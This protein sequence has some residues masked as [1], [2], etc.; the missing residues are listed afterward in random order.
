MNGI[1]RFALGLANMPAATVADLEKAMPGMQRLCEIATEIAAIA[2][3]NQPLTAHV[4][5][6][7][8]IVKK[9]YP[10]FVAVIP[11]VEEL[12]QFASQKG[13]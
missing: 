9:A 2:A 12:I 3:K 8:P 13:V 4:D 6:I 5:Q 11:T 7:E 1:L 10:D